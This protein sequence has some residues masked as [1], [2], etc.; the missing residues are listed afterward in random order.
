MR[1]VHKLLIYE[2]VHNELAFVR[3]VTDGSTPE[4]SRWTTDISCRCGRKKVNIAHQNELPDLH[5]YNFSY[6][7]I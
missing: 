3:Y 6:S 1:E 7:K 2:Y 5:A 4:V